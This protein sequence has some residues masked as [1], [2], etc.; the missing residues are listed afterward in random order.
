MTKITVFFFALFC[1]MSF[2]AS[3]QR[4]Q[5]FKEI[6]IQFESSVIVKKNS[7]IPATSRSPKTSTYEGLAGNGKP[8][9]SVFLQVEEYSLNTP[10]NHIAELIQK[11]LSPSKDILQ[12]NGLTFYI[13]SQKSGLNDIAYYLQFVIKNKR[14][15]F[16][17]DGKS[18][19]K[20]ELDRIFKTIAILK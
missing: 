7:D 6:G 12:K 11:S 17:I 14:Y 16:T 20:A 1:A 2:N 15:T 13:D 3:A 10:P 19:T 9:L 4:K 18:G 5:I 8:Y